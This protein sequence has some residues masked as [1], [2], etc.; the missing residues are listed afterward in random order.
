VPV[1]VT[2]QDATGRLLYA[3]ETAAREGGFSS[4]SALVGTTIPEILARFELLGEDG[5]PLPLETL[6][7]ARVLAGEEPESILI[8]IR[9]RATG[10]RRWAR[11]TAKPVHGVSGRPELAINLWYDVTEEQRTKESVREFLELTAALGAS[12]DFATT[13]ERLADDL[14]PKMADWCAIDLVENGVQQPLVLR[15]PDAAKSEALKELA[16]RR[17]DGI[18]ARNVVP[19]LIPRVFDSDLASVAND[20]AG[21][22]LLR[23]LDV[24]SAIVVPLTNRGR[25]TGAMV[26]ATGESGRTYDERDRDVARAIAERASLLLD[27]ARAYRAAVDAVRM[28]DDFLSIAAHELRTPIASL[29]LLCETLLESTEGEVRRRLD[30]GLRQVRRLGNLVE[31]LLDVGRLS[32]DSLSLQRERVDVAQLVREVTARLAQE[33]EQAH[34]ELRVAC[35]DS[36]VAMIDR[37]RIDQVVT[38]LVNNA[39]KY[40][41]RQPVDIEC[42]VHDRE[43]HIKVTDRGIGIARSDHERIFRRF[44]RAVGGRNFPGLGLGLWIVREIVAAHCGRIDI[45][46]EPGKGATF[47][48]VLPRE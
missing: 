16:A 12:L 2:V 41:A 10:R 26:M 30:I 21:L 34:C 22:A 24:R 19:R 7:G 43:V 1:T 48:V 4:P 18:R 31:A 14:V 9:E 13:L 37:L 35:K 23:S 39:I 47:D 36:C 28:R 44:E 27:N 46:S 25:P 33:A 6:P 42:T 20:S 40:G 45:H 38:N 3:N 5:R 11:A 32:G 15:G 29:S 8:Q 17:N